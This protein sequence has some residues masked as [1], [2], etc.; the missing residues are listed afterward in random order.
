MAQQEARILAVCSLGLGFS[1]KGLQAG[2]KL[3]PHVIACDAGSSDFGPYYLGSGVLQKSPVSLRRDLELLIEGALR[4]GVP[5]ITGSVGGAGGGPHLEACVQ[6][7]KDI[8]LDR[9]WRFRLAEIDCRIQPGQLKRK[10]EEGKVHPLDGFAPLSPD[11]VDGM[12]AMVGMIGAEPY[13]R[14]LD[15]GAQVILAG[16]STDPAIF[17]AQPLRMGLAADLVWHAAK[18][19]D[20][21]YLATT[22]PEDGSPVMAR[23]HPDH[24][25]I[26]P[27]R[28]GSVC[29]VPSVAS[30]TLHE[31]PDP[32]EVT[33]PTGVIDTHD[34]E[35][36]QETETTVRVTGSRYRAVATPTIKIEGARLVG[37]RNI[38]IAGLRDPRLV[39]RIDDFLD[40]YRDRIMPVGAEPRHSAGRLPAAVPSLWQ[41]RRHGA[42]GAGQA[43]PQPRARPDRGR[44][45]PHR[46]HSRRDRDPARPHRLTASHRRGDDGRRQLRLSLL[47]EQ[48]QGGTGLRVERLARDGGDAGGA[49]GAVPDNPARGLK[50]YGQA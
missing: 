3:D 37:Y 32:F 13:M 19:V 4:L 2:L 9:G 10:I 17:A 6:L 44:G 39:S 1:Y 45:R 22:R 28:V 47:A 20:K 21:G 29:T 31:N 8:A 23:I 18:C 11:D 48:H 15:M 7:V 43:D 14:A 30:I 42:A 34:S 24:F 50:D 12:A 41:G 26:E 33:Q 36:A 27:T 5:F 40:A 46:S 38:L 49:V 35:Y 16:R 25:T